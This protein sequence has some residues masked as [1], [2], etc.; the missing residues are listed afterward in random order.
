MKEDTKYVISVHYDENDEIY[1][2]N[3]YDGYHSISVDRIDDIPRIIKE[4]EK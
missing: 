3:I 4:L 1:D 2:V